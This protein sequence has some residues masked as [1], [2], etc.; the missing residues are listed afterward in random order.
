MGLPNSTSDATSARQITEHTVTIKFDDQSNAA[1]VKPNPDD[2]SPS[3]YQNQLSPDLNMHSEKHNIN[4][5]CSV[6]Q[7]KPATSF[8]SGGAQSSQPEVYSEMVSAGKKV[9][10]YDPIF[11][12]LDSIPEAFRESASPCKTGQFNSKMSPYKQ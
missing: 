7:P 2:T 4:L 8:L 6:I 3:F 10:K 5:V 11:N 1:Q 9:E 12:A